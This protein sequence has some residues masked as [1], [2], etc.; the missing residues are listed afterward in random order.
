MSFKL[1]LDAEGS[2]TAAIVLDTLGKVVLHAMPVKADRKAK[3]RFANDRLLFFI[4]EEGQHIGML[5]VGMDRI[6]AYVHLPENI[7]LCHL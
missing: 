5:T 6:V 2:N 1:Q 3:P 7:R 4:L